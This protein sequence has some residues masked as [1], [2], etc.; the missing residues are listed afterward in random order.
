M[1]SL[2]I[3]FV[4]ASVASP[5]GT[6]PPA[7]TQEAAL[8]PADEVKQKFLL[9]Q[10]RMEFAVVIRDDLVRARLGEKR[11]EGGVNFQSE[12]I[13][14]QLQKLRDSEP[15]LVAWKPTE[16]EQLEAM[17]KAF[18]EFMEVLSEA[19]DRAMG[20][21]SAEQKKQA[22]R[23]NKP[24]PPRPTPPAPYSPLDNAL[25]RAAKIADHARYELEMAKWRGENASR[26][27]APSKVAGIEK[28]KADLL[29]AFRETSDEAIK[30]FDEACDR[31]LPPI[32]ADGHVAKYAE[33]RLIESFKRIEVRTET[34][35]TLNDCRDKTRIREVVYDVTNYFGVNCHATVVVY[36]NQ[37]PSNDWRVSKENETKGGF[38]DLRLPE[39]NN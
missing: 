39:G 1:H 3:L 27:Q 20:N 4:V 5:L 19:S 6:M 12:N 9:W 23:G 37:S 2:Q 16:S 30:K 32:V 15:N 22:Q 31:F 38:Y 24:S 34:P 35:I 26:A 17:T 18:G 36:R 14:K 10:C 28:N 8:E 7:L 33:Q 25:Q 13:K 29:A 11:I 21:M